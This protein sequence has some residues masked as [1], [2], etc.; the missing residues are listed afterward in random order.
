MAE[1]QSTKI[2]EDLA[3]AY[4][5]LFIDLPLARVKWRLGIG[6]EKEASETAWK[7]YDTGVRLATTTID[8]LYRAPLFGNVLAQSLTVALRGQQVSNAL[9]GA[10]FTGLWQMVGLPTTAE[11]QALRAEVQALREDVRALRTTPMGRTKKKAL[12]QPEE[13]LQ[14]LPAAA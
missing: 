13:R 12:G 10:F 1:K 6:A 14:S 7:A 8:N 3:T 2:T 11:T 4:K 9:A 5:T